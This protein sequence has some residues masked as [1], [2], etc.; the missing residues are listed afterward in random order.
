[1]GL[2]DFL[3]GNKEIERERQEEFRLKQE[4]ETKRHA[5]EQRRQAEVR[6][7]AEE[8]R[9]RQEQ[10]RQEAILSNFDFD[11]NCHQR[12]E[13]G[14]PVKG[15]QVCPRFI[16]IR[17]NTNGCRGYHL[18]NG[19]GYILTA[20]NGDTGQPQ[21]AA[22]PM[23]VVK[24]SD[25][26]ILLKGYTVSAQTP[27][28]W[29]DIDL[30]DYGF[31]IILKKGKVDKC[32]LHMY[33]RN[34]DLEYRIRSSQQE[35]TSTCA[36][37]ELTETEKFVNEALAQLQMGNDGDA[38]YHPLYEAWRS[39][40][41]DPAQLSEIQNYGEYGKG[42]MIFLSFGTVSDI[43]DQQQLASLAYL[44]ISKAIN[45]KPMDCNLYKNR[46]LLMLTN[47][48]AFQYTVSSAVNTGDG[49]D[50]MGFSNFEGRDSMYKMEFADLN[51]SPRLLLI[52]LFA[53]KYRDLKL[54]IA[55]NFFG[56]GKNE[57]SIVTEGKALHAKVLAYLENKVIKYGNIDF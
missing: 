12:Y 15:L 28:G 19:D 21:F 32:I 57:A 13:S 40:R 14:T 50:F 20:T 46:I 45:N 5:E 49:L 37:K 33:D 34:V 41:Y 23:R 1:M 10:E 4:A 36:K 56:Q 17:K 51:A 31:S 54:K 48:E 35:A 24:I 3:F 27:F 7:R 52:D 25:N 16:R 38:T 29:Q 39:C 8:Q 9:K 55:S 2:F 22:K 11:S 26:E 18:K 42:L 43:D 30:S 47:H 44:F 6:R 53:S